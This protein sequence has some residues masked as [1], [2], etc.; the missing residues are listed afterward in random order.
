MGAVNLGACNA[1]PRVPD[2]ALTPTCMQCM[3]ALDMCAVIILGVQ[4]RASAAAHESV[5][6]KLCSYS[7]RS[8]CALA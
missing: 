3:C 8:R 1:L 4:L 6:A 5:R 7:D 2:F